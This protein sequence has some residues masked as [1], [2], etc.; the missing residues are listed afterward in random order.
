VQVDAA[1]QAAIEAYLEGHDGVDQLAEAGR[2]GP[3]K[4]AQRYLALLV[5]A[6]VRT[7]ADAAS[8]LALLVSAGIRTD[9]DAASELALAPTRSSRWSNRSKPRSAR[10]CPVSGRISDACPV[11]GHHGVGSS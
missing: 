9:A 1:Y 5:S 4:P 11:A 7:D 2:G 3:S 8:E 6:G 10:S